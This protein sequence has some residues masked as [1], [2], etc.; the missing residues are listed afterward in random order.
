MTI[1]PLLC[2]ALGAAIV[3]CARGHTSVVA[4][5]RWTLVWR[6]E[7]NGDA[8]TAPDT[9]SWSYTLRDGCDAGI[10][11]WGNAEKEFYTASRE[12]VALDGRGHLAITARPAPP[13][14]ACYYGPC[15]Y[16]SSRIRTFGKVNAV[17]PG[18]V[19]ARIK[20]PAGQGLWPAFWL[21]GSN[22][23][24]TPWPRS[25]ELDVME[26]HGSKPG[27]TSSAIHGPGY[28]GETPF[29]HAYSLAHTSFADDFHLFA[30]EWDAAHVHFFVDNTLHYSMTARDAA[31]YG[32]WVF[33]QPFFIVLN[34][35]VGGKFDGDVGSD[36]VLPA[37]MLVDYVRV[38]TVKK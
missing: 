10:C 37:T 33:D 15:R 27:A 25:G 9:A 2:V 18:R 38:Y 11:G 29:V 20:L 8:G 26:N 30:V 5:T 6:D 23:P 32:P 34:L 13:G 16:T 22:Y 28:S 14:L 36:A 21:L 17:A 24:A 12:N 3:S 31:R 19:E 7:F 35:A 1:R 4:P